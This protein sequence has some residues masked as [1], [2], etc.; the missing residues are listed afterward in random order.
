[1]DEKVNRRLTILLSAPVTPFQIIL[2]KMLPYAI[3][4]M[5]TTALIAVLTHANIWLALAIFAPT[6]L[7]IFAIYLMVPLFLSHLLKTPPLFPCW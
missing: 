2:G 6:I 5:V 3:F 7:F 1:M 4:A